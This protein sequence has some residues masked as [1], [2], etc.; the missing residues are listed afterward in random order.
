M[1]TATPIVL[2]LASADVSLEQVGGKGRSLSAMAAARLPVPIG[3]LVSTTA[4]ENFVD[5]NELRGRILEVVAVATTSS[6][7]SVE[8]ASASIASLF[9]A[10]SIP[11][12]L[13]APVRQ[14]YATLGA[15]VA[16]AVRS[17][18]TAEDLPEL[19]FA[20]QQDSFLNV[21][22]PDA[23]MDAVL[24]CWASLWTARAISYRTQMK[25]DHRLVKMGVVVQV[26]VDA[27]VSGILFTANPVT[28]DRSEM[29]V[30]ASF[31]LGEAVVGGQV[32]PD[33]YVLDRASFELTDM[34]IGAKQEM[35]VATGDQGTSTQLVPESRRD[36]SSLPADVLAELAS[37]GARAEALFD[38]QPQDLEWAVADGQ[39]WLLQSRPITNLPVFA[40]ADVS[41]EAPSESARLVRRQVVENM[42]GPLS[43]LFEELYLKEGLDRGMDGLMTDLGLPINMDEFIERPL[44]VTV[45]GYGY[46]RYDLRFSWRS[47]LLIPRILVWFVREFPRFQ[48]TITSRWRDEGLAEYL[49]TIEQWGA[50]DL[51]T[52]PD[53]Q[54][55]AGVRALA[56]ADARYWFYTTMMVGGAKVTEGLLNW[57]VTS[58]LVKRDLNSG[59]FLSGFPSTTLQAQE[60]LEAIAKAIRAVES[61]RELVVTGPVE[62][63]LK[64][65]QANPAGD[66]IVAQVRQYLE[67]YGHLVYNLDF[68]EPTQLEDPLPVLLALKTLVDDS[69]Y[70]TPARQA[71]MARKRE[72]LVRETL[73]SFGPVRRW[74]FQKSLGWAQH[75][76]P[77]REEALFYMGAAW[78]TLRRLALE[79]GRRLVEAG[80]LSAADGVFYLDSGE[81][82]QANAARR[83]GRARPDLLTRADER[84]TLRKA[85]MELHP[86]GRV[87]EDLRFKFG[88]FD[89]TR[90]FEFWETQKR[91]AP[92]S[93]T[94]SGFAVSPGTVTGRATVILSSADFA[95]MQ[96]DTIL[97]CRT[98]TPA[99]TPLFAQAS[100]LVTDIGAIL[101]HGSI[102]AREYGIPAVLGTGNVT[103][104]VVT[105][106]RITVDGDAGTVTL[107]E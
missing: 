22:G 38:G 90:F 97:V 89:F 47:L 73:A 50:L 36:K 96:P 51:D 75:Y 81:L 33:T 46:C 10:A 65:L 32:T 54:L 29:V 63:L 3:F 85:R 37:L 105:G 1:T 84:R 77:H 82:V 72:V 64:A 12:E 20:G 24:R 53:E 60:H 13:A 15:D 107:L 68:V 57:V 61:L 76:G 104:R 44:F 70:D 52:T 11:A 2:P 49:A 41:W 55:L 26:M 79:L 67:R 66:P 83:E 87:P 88:P 23:L 99:W 35:I 18:A 102:V 92:D 101:A 93:N 14:A 59:M 19:S 40:L 62:E 27:E 58:R 91:N 8:L 86:P 98:T 7:G 16:V 48:R 6:S 43:P 28:G 4:Y 106:Q 9:A 80:T 94:L 56:N 45:N 71:K 42:P 69:N 31:G 34:V 21:C 39:C 5:A 103:Q 100:G 30:N 95:D 17:S 25:I 78:P 74:W